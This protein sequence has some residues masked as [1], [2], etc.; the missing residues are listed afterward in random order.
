MVKTKKA[1]ILTKLVVLALLVYLATTL[2]NLRSQ[3]Q[4]AQT[5]RDTLTQQVADQNQLNAEL[6]AAV[7]DSDAPARIADAAREKLGLVEPG[8]K[9]FVFTN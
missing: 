7:K 4:S 1:G 9:V 2:L 3:I 8:E 6:N 5:E